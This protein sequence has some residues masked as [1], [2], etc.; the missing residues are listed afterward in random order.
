M[1]ETPRGITLTALING[2]QLPQGPENLIV[3]YTQLYRLLYDEI[4][5]RRKTEE[6][7]LRII[8]E[9][10][11]IRAMSNNDFKEEV[12]AKQSLY[13]DLL[14]NVLD[15]ESV[16]CTS[17]IIYLLEQFMI[18]N[19]LLDVYFNQFMKRFIKM[20]MKEEVKQRFM[21]LIVKMNAI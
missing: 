13:F 9:V 15:I 19:L 20:S 10:T 5:Q 7:S 12:L 17:I 6:I 2:I 14:L 8:K 16:T 18:D 21:K 4:K 3:K 1:T 11:R